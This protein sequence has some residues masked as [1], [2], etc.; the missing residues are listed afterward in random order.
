MPH[1]PHHA[2]WLVT[3]IIRQ[4]RSRYGLLGLGLRQD[5]AQ[6]VPLVPGEAQY[7]THALTKVEAQRRAYR[8]PLQPG[9]RPSFQHPSI[10]GALLAFWK[11][12]IAGR[13]V[14]RLAPA[15]ID[16]NLKQI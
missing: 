4:N 3:K 15:L 8:R 6:A 1:V 16:G 14:I 10:P 7:V 11:A 2:N 13:I 9:D 12:H 5:E